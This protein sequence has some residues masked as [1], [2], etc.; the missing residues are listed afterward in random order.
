MEPQH[1]YKDVSSVDH[2]D[3]DSS[4][5]VESL[6][7]MEKQWAADTFTR[8]RRSKRNA[9]VDIIKA[10]R[11]FVIIGL[12]L[13]MVGLLAKDQGMLRQL[14]LGTNKKSTSAGDV[15]GDITGWG[16]HSEW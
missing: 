11:W 13:I 16:P 8:S 15:G 9:C 14:G 1:A 4:T 12:Q 3:D 7:G 6:V 5:E 10:S 2:H